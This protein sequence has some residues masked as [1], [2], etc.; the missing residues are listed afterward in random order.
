MRK[1][2]PPQGFT[3]VELL[4][5]IGIIGI[6]IAMLLPA[7]NKARQSADAIACA[8]NLR[9]LGQA[10]AMY[11]TENH[12]FFPP[13]QAQTSASNP[14]F[15]TSYQ[16]R[17][18]HLLLPYLGDSLNVFHCPSSSEIDLIGPY[19]KSRALSPLTDNPV[20]PLNYGAN[21]F[22][23]QD[24]F[25]AGVSPTRWTQIKEPQSK[26]WITD[27]RSLPAMSTNGINIV[28]SS[29]DPTNAKPY[30]AFR[31][32]NNT[33]I[34]VLFVDGHVNAYLYYPTGA[35]TRSIVHQLKWTIDKSY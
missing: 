5:V 15:P 9:Q 19:Y 6:L 24:L 23:G 34:N 28:Q 31:H 25:A 22:I 10:G 30:C 32:L 20:L 2:S 11:G 33:R 13:N 14:A 3:L 17:W 35:D 21:L 1:T 4:V 16:G 26:V 27:S 8:S 18:V 12:G 7:L 29:A